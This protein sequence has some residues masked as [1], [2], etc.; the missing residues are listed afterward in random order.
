[1]LLNVYPTAASIARLASRSAPVS[2]VPEQAAL[3]AAGDAWSK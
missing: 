1:M 2:A 3:Q